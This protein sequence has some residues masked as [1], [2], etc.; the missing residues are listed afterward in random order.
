MPVGGLM[1]RDSGVV[2]HGG[3]V[4]EGGIYVR[5]QGGKPQRGVS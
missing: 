4:R 3:A 1:V 5:A 2:M